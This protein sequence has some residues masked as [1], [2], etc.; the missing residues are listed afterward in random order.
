MTEKHPS[1]PNWLDRLLTRPKADVSRLH[2]GMWFL[3]QL[4]HHGARELREHR[5]RQMAAALTFAAARRVH[6]AD[7]FVRAGKFA[8]WLP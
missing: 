2:S 3:L 5:A 8:G 7:G 4:C 6:E 1:L